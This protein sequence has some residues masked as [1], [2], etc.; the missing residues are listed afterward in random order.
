VIRPT[1][2][3]VATPFRLTYIARENS[4]FV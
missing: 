1:I 3:N 4:R 2:K